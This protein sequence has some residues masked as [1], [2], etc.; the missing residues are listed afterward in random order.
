MRA[1]VLDRSANIDDSP[2]VMREV[3]DPHPGG[4]EVRVRVSVCAVCRTDL[5][6]IEG[7]LPE[8]KRPIIPGHQVVGVVDELGEGCSALKEGD[9]IGIAWLRSTDG[10]C[11]FCRASRANLCPSSR[12]TGYHSDGG[13]AEYTVVPEEF[14][15]RLPG[16]FDDVVGSPRPQTRRRAGSRKAAA[17]GV[18]LF[19]PRRSPDRPASRLQDL[20][21]DPQ[22]EPRA[23]GSDN[24]GGLGRDGHGGS[25]RQDGQRHSLCTR[26]QTGA[27]HH[28]GPRE[29][30]HPVDRRHS[31]HRRT[32]A[33][34]RAAS[35]LRQG[36]SLG[37]GEHTGGWT[38]TA[39]GSRRS[40]CT[41]PREDVLTSR[42]QRR[43]PG[44]EAQPRRWNRRVAHR[45]RVGVSVSRNGRFRLAS[46]KSV[47]QRR[48]GRRP[49]A[50][51]SP[52]KLIR[53]GPSTRP[54]PPSCKAGGW[55][56]QKVL[57]IRA[58]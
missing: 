31:S 46:S 3:D 30:R 17:R 32:F 15:Y 26:R 58:G 12:Y 21:S 6:I 55:T 19:G 50:D 43:T 22:R 45:Q 16:R 18:R 47:P 25:P 29:G 44:H 5:H 51:L 41:P 36:D 28:G 7:D 35:I 33:Q 23:N 8:R 37:C 34:L 13:Y 9:R 56:I 10:T 27:S 42:R 52:Q 1:M 54:Y 38:R 11:Q 24:G 14:A 57:R 4:G 53:A 20:R 48:I 2:L 40:R 39:G 49:V